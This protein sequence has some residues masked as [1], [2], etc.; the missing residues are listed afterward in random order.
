MIQI[1]N[2]SDR[3]SQSFNLVGENG[4]QILFLLK[5]RPTQN[6]WFFDLSYED[7]QI[8]DAHI[9]L[10]VNLLRQWSNVLP[11]G[12]T[13]T[14]NNK[15]DPFL[16]EDFQNGNFSLFVLNSNEVEQ[17]EGEYFT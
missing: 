14:G 3:A 4:E 7:F 5:Y 13:C 1:T 12:L 10:S 8:Y 2:I 6:G 9:G 17:F 16:I 11:F 15:F